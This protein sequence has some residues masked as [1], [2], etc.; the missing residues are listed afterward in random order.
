MCM[1]AELKFKS[2]PFRSPGSSPPSPRSPVR[3]PS[4]ASPQTPVTPPNQVKIS[5]EHNGLIKKLSLSFVRLYKQSCFMQWPHVPTTTV[6]GWQGEAFTHNKQVEI[7]YQQ[8]F[9]LS[10]YISNISSNKRS[11]P[12]ASYSIYFFLAFFLTGTF[13]LVPRWRRRPLV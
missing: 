6:P 2:L 1:S 13:R 5:F 8:F 9:P 7:S 3:S 12:L 11:S 4:M 10:Y